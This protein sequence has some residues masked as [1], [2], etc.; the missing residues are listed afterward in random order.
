PRDLRRREPQRRHG[1]RRRRHLLIGERRVGVGLPRHDDEHADRDGRDD[2][3]E[4]PARAPHGSDL[5]RGATSAAPAAAMKHAART[6]APPHAGA[7]GAARPRAPATPAPRPAMQHAARTAAPPANAAPVGSSG[8]AG[9]SPGGSGPT[10]TS[11][12]APRA[13]IRRSVAPSSAPS[14]AG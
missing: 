11:S 13:T 5:L 2:A 12:P 6:A 9:S 8:A 3:R 1:L 4:R 10:P 14:S 7:H